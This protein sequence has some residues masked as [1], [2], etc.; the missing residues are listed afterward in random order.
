MEVETTD[1]LYSIEDI[2]KA[3]L[4]CPKFKHHI[5][6]DPAIDDLHEQ[7]IEVIEI[8]MFLY[9]LTGKRDYGNKI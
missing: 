4:R 3:I 5:V 1:K 2:E 7:D 6:P 8:K 9:R